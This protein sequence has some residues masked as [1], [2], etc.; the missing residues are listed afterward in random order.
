MVGQ[1]ILEVTVNENNVQVSN[2]GEN[3]FQIT[4]TGSKTIARIN[5]DVSTA[6]YPDSV[7]DPF[8][9]GRRYHI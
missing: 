1:A 4:N 7:F 3:S 2:F 8:G 6:L 9:L 5:L